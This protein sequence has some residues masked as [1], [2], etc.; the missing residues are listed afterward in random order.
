MCRVPVAAR[1]PAQANTAKTVDPSIKAARA[2]ELETARRDLEAAEAKVAAVPHPAR[3]D[4][5]RTCNV[6]HCRAG[7]QPR[8]SIHAHALNLPRGL[9]WCVRMLLTAQKI[10]ALHSLLSVSCGCVACCGLQVYNL[11]GN[12]SLQP[13]LL[14]T[15]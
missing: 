3:D 5:T 13:W 4:R 2:R 6:L 12:S 15:A 10:C 8:T 7:A 11:C 9:W 1:L 14:E